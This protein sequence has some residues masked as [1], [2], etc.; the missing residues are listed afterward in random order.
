VSLLAMRTRGRC[1]VCVCVRICCCCCR[2]LHVEHSIA[3][4]RTAA[5]ELIPVSTTGLTAQ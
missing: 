1:A 5:P 4:C 3:S 2:F